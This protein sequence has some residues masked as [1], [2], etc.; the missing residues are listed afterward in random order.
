MNIQ[1]CCDAHGLR[2][3][4]LGIFSHS[5]SEHCAV[6]LLR[7][8]LRTHAM[9]RTSFS[10]PIQAFL[11]ICWEC[12]F[13]CSKWLETWPNNAQRTLDMYHGS[14]HAEEAHVGSTSS[15][16]L[17]E[18]CW[19]YCNVGLK[20]VSTRNVQRNMLYLPRFFQ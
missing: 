11:S 8:L 5:Y 19:T 3:S 2:Q 7:F 13:S 18:N 15:Q 12:C 4:P 20:W 6:N 14:K 1:H 17:L 9:I 10:V 16:L